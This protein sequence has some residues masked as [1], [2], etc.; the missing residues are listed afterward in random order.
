MDA[1]SFLQSWH[2]EAVD[3]A[4][5]AG[6]QD[7]DHVSALSAFRLSAKHHLKTPYKQRQI[8]FDAGVFAAACHASLEPDID[9]KTFFE[10]WFKPF[11][12]VPD[13]GLG[14]ITG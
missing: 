6:W 2:L 8:A 13:Q 14:K 12:I 4:A 11:L 3:F 10:S 5:L 9:P 1:R 7:D